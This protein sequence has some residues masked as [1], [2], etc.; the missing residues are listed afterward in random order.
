M[1]ST[2]EL[3][4]ALETLVAC[5]SP[6]SDPEATA[7]CLDVAA[8]LI[9]AWLGEK[10]VSFDEQGRRH[11][12]YRF[13]SPAD[14]TAPLKI[15]LLAH[16]DTVWPHGTLSEIPFTVQGG[17]VRGPGVF[18]MKGGLVQGLAALADLPPESLDGVGLLLNT[19]EEI[20]SG[21]SRDL[22]ERTADGARAVLVLEP[23]AGGALK[24]ER[25]GVSMYDVHFAGKA[26]HA[27]LE[28]EK[29]VNAL[30][31]L[32]HFVLAL[33]SL[34]RPEQGTTVTPTVA[35]A[36]TTR[37][38]VPE[39]ATVMVDVRAS[40]VAEQDR[41]HSDLLALVPRLAGAA[42]R[43][44]G[45][46]N[47]PPLEHRAAKDLFA[48]ARAHFEELGHGSIDEVHVGGGSD[49]NFTAG[50]GIPTLDGLGAVGDGAHARHEHLLA[51]AMIPR[52]ELVRELIRG[53][54]S[55]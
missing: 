38:S 27:G 9:G 46:P 10:P 20:G 45:G 29:G 1:R 55:A 2:S 24:T 7:R 18:D 49:G 31:E 13:G 54:T 17:V 51:D 33:D 6:S 42:I 4:E 35:T 19:D 5:E 41:V 22:I 37:N 25:K 50:L 8:E 15:L 36:G 34:A 44:D 3:L 48:S 11:D 14:P 26:A 23:S 47:R 43:V 12:V 40:T 32:S 39:S 52:A 16:V 53:V 30:V 28:P 21:T